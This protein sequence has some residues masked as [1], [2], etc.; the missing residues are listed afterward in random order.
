MLFFWFQQDVLSLHWGVLLLAAMLVGG[1]YLDSRLGE[2]AKFHPLVGFG[3]WSRLLEHVL[4]R[5]SGAPGYLVGVVAVVAALLPLILIIWMLQSSATLSLI[6][7]C[8]LHL[9]ILYLCIGWHSLQESCEGW[10]GT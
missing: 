2:P 6:G 3:R 1:V 9:V 5:I 8:L 7:T 10:A 4:N